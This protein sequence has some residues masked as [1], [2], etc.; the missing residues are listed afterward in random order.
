MAKTPGRPKHLGT[1]VC[2][3]GETRTIEIEIPGSMTHSGKPEPFQITVH[4]ETGIPV[5]YDVRVVA[6]P[7]PVIELV[8]RK[9]TAKELSQAEARV[10]T[11]EMARADRERRMGRQNAIFGV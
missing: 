8:I 3:V 1:C 9:P 10:R 5:A 11:F 7:D 6:D 4:N 2:C